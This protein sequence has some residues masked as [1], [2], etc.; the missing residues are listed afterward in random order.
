MAIKT[1]IWTVNGQ[2]HQLKECLLSSEHLLEDMIVSAPRVLSDE[3]MLIGRQESTGRGGADRPVGDRP[4][5]L[6][7]ADRTQTR[8]H[9]A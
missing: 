5:C 1:Q 7:G 2:P 3:W 8:P 6:T 9:T 4:G